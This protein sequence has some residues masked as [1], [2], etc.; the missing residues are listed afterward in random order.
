MDA[1]WSPEVGH[2]LFFRPGTYDAEERT[3]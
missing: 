2:F 3:D 1:F